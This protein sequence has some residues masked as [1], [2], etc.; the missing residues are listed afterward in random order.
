MS[1]GGNQV[2][3][4]GE[5]ELGDRTL[6][7]AEVGSNHCGDENVARKSLLAAAESGADAVKFQ[8][9]DPEKLID[10]TTPVLSYIAQTHQTQRE[11]FR[12][13]RLSRDIFLE[14]ADL[15]KRK[16]VLFLVTPFDEEAVDFL[17]PLVPAF[18]IASGDLTNARLLKRVVE[19]KKPVI[20]STGFAAV[21]EI[22]WLVRQIPKPQLCLM[23]CVGAYP[24]PPEHVHLEAIRFLKDKYGVPVGF[25]DH[26]AGITAAM[27]AVAKGASLIEKHFLLSRDLPAADVGLSVTPEEFCEMVKGIRQIERM[28]G[29]YGKS[30]QPS[31]EYFRV[32]LRRSVYAARNLR[33]GEI[34][35]EKDVM[36]LR[37]FVPDGIEA[38]EIASL[39]GRTVR[40]PVDK[41]QPLFP[42]A[43]GDRTSRSKP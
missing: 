13:L 5:V 4:I 3:R 17:D 24:T 33:A 31:E 39:E 30:V 34:L 1:R 23:H 16:G 20:V 19:T 36:P 35:N 7:I 25:S 27:A 10:A 32:Q 8:M 29:T 2:M 41:D 15:A 38:R 40:V 43:L 21:E 6:V 18:K 14:L 11:R 42:G 37:P 26:T 28:N 9:Y 22:D 12:S